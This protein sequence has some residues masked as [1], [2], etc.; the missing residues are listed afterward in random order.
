M[1]EVVPVTEYL[2]ASL[3]PSESQRIGR[4]VEAAKAPATLR[5]Y[6]SRLKPWA[7]FCATTGRRPCPASPESLAAFLTEVADQGRSVSWLGQFLAAVSWS[8][9]QAGHPTPTTHPGIKTT[10]KGIRRTL[11]VKRHPKAPATV[12]L[13]TAMVSH[14]D[15][16]TL[17]GQRD[18]AL[19]L[20]GFAGA[21]RRSELVA[22][23]VSDLKKTK[24]GM[25]V[26]IRR[27]KTDQEGEGRD[28]AIIPGA[29]GQ[30]P[31]KA[32]DEWLE[33]AGITEGP[34][35]RSVSRWGA[36]GKNLSARIVAS[37]VKRH[38]IAAKLDPAEFAGHSLRRGFVT[39]ARARGASESAVCDITGHSSLAMMDLYDER[40]KFQNHAAKGLL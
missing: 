19:L 10:M 36:V 24:D 39:S 11:G 22:L 13:L 5:A 9:E 8:H 21:F 33:A 23:E 18:A 32:C 25:L 6:R 38:A 35:F 29:A 16:T 1:S 26:T 17:I 12:E 40:E 27:S 34:L 15:Q 20:L 2:P 30:C 28:V 7:E 14:I 31:I 4:Y 37:V 3:T